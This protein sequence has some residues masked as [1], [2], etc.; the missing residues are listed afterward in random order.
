MGV[1]HEG[2]LRSSLRYFCVAF[3]LLEG[4]FRA[5][6]HAGWAAL[7][8]KYATLESMLLFLFWVGCFM[9]VRGMHALLRPTSFSD[10][11]ID[12]EVARAA[13]ARS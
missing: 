6:W 5:R 7:T 9:F 10:K 4:V 12:T 8:F 13:R 2:A 1:A 3:Q 11:L